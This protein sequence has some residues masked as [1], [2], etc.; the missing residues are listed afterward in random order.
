MM[1]IN[2]HYIGP[3][4]TYVDVDIDIDIH[5]VAHLRFGYFTEYK[6]LKL[7]GKKDILG[8]GKNVPAHV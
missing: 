1:A 5:E 6:L 8:R 2:V 3:G 4:G 7:K